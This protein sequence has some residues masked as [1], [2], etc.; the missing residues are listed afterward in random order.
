MS[1]NDCMTEALQ[2]LICNEF[3]LAKYRDGRGRECV[4]YVGE[5]FGIA[6]IDK[7]IT[8]SDVPSEAQIGKITECPAEDIV[9]GSIMLR[10]K[11]NYGDKSF[12]EIITISH[13]YE[14]SYNSSYVT[15]YDGGMKASL[16]QVAHDLWVRY[17]NQTSKKDDTI[18]LLTVRDEATAVW[19][20]VRYL[21][22]QGKRRIEV[23]VY[24]GKARK[25]NLCDRV[26]LSLP[27]QTN[28]TQIEAIIEKKQA[29]RSRG[30]TNLG[31]LL[32]WDPAT[33]PASV[34]SSSASS[35]SASGSSSSESGLKSSSSGSSSSYMESSESSESD[36]SD[37]TSSAIGVATD[38][39]HVS[40]RNPAG[41][42]EIVKT[43]NSGFF[44]IGELDAKHEE[45]V[46]ITDAQTNAIS[47]PLRLDHQLSAGNIDVGFGVGVTLR[48]RKTGTVASSEI[49]R[50]T[51]D[52]STADTN[53]KLG[54]WLRSGNA[55]REVLRIDKD[56]YAWFDPTT[57]LDTNLYRAAAN[58][59]KTD[60]S[61]QVGLAL[62][63]GFAPD[64]VSA[65]GTF[66]KDQDLETSLY[67]ENENNHASAQASIYVL[68]ESTNRVSIHSA[69]TLCN[70]GKA[71]LSDKG[72][73][74]IES[75]NVN[76]LL[77]NNYS[78]TALK[79]GTN[80]AVR[81]TIAAAGD[82]TIAAGLGLGVGVAPD[83]NT[84]GAFRK[85]QNSHTDLNLY[86][87]TPGTGAR[88]ILGTGSDVADINFEVT[89]SAYTGTGG[90][91]IAQVKSWA[92]TGGFELRNSAN[93]AMRFITNDVVRMTIAA[94]GY[95]TAFP[96]FLLNAA[97]P[98]FSA[99]AYDSSTTYEGVL[100]LG[101]S[102]GTLGSESAL[103]S[104][105]PLGRINFV[106]RDGTGLKVG[107]SLRAKA[108]A[109]WS[110]A[111][112]C[113]TLIEMWACGNS[114]DTETRTMYWGASAISALVAFTCASSLA[115]TG[116]TT[117]KTI[118][119]AAQPSGSDMVYGEMAFWIDTDD[120][121]KLYLIYN[122]S[123]TYKK[124]QL[125]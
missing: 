17:G 9:S 118:S 31:L 4:A 83:A 123:G 107:G 67:L 74:V 69:S 66:R 117:I 98:T 60:G 105:D 99:V 57:G 65:I 41:T 114:S 15:G 22:W 104:G 20:L 97:S 72:L 26:T 62:G 3:F 79:L 13:I 87:A 90:A 108:D 103:S 58:Q 28:G 12:S 14:Y 121:D 5:A 44:G 7:H 94:G 64:P 119:Q 42:V 2:K 116:S 24:Y 111:T 49:G 81:M 124:V 80:N 100:N 71:G 25:W 18:D 36:S 120:S 59:L 43:N 46:C 84:I 45:H 27:H 109:S 34:S 113:P 54:M 30:V 88:C 56:A 77:I 112:D 53:S 38:H 115:V 82:V 102:R 47:Y 51:W 61:L 8:L 35:T 6:N 76:G 68:G 96:S 33:S 92:N 125:T 85:D 50:M 73:G 21:Q 122:Q 55:I 101:H 110:G 52:Y 78:N 63:V 48:T 39:Y 70:L 32:F 1:T 11:Q 93:T 29:A 75:V 23:P 10:Y 16:W 37:S 91:G 89:S 95:L 40:L 106:G 19:F 86:N